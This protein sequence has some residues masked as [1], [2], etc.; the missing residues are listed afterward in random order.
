[1]DLPYSGSDTSESHT[2]SGDTVPHRCDGTPPA[3][4]T[5]LAQN[6]Q[7]GSETTAPIHHPPSFQEFAHKAN[8]A[9][10]SAPLVPSEPVL[11]TEIQQ[12]SADEFNRNMKAAEQATRGLR[13]LKLPR[14]LK[15]K[16]KSLEKSLVSTKRTWEETGEIPDDEAIKIHQGPT[17]A[18]SSST[19]TF[20]KKTPRKKVKRDPPTKPVD[21][22]NKELPHPPANPLPSTTSNRPMDQTVATSQSTPSIISG[23]PCE[24]GSQ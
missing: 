2:D 24:P 9:T 19:K 13:N 21:L 4:T 7:I 11:D 22:L 1:M 14:S 5:I 8:K 20:T 6:F 10:S 16:V 18:H 12:I 23:A 15:E 17:S 3:T